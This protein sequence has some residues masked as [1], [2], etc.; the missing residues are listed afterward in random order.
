M[1]PTFTKTITSN[2]LQHLPISVLI[3]KKPHNFL[4]LPFLFF[5]LSATGIM[6]G[7]VG[8]GVIFGEATAGANF[9]EACATGSNFGEATDVI[10]GDSLPDKL[11]RPCGIALMKLS[12]FRS[13]EGTSAQ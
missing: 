11:R 5:P 1:G 3:T 13:C 6:L 7:E 10:L 4:F 2:L 12:M 8:V 9:G